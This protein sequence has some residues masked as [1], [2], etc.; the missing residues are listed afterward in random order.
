MGIMRQGRSPLL[1]LEAILL[2]ARIVEYVV[3]HELV[4]L[5]CPHHS[6]DF[7]RRV[8]LAMPDFAS[9]KQWLARNAQEASAV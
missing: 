8:E 5:R 9:R 4:H 2:P 6:P 7:W 1:P 3:V